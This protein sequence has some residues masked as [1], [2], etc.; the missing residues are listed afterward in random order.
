MAVLEPTLIFTPAAGRLFSLYTFPCKL[1]V[2]GEGEGI[3][4][5]ILPGSLTS[6]W[7]CIKK[8]DKKIK[9]KME[10]EFLMCGCLIYV[11][12]ANEKGRGKSFSPQKSL[13]R[14]PELPPE[15]H[16]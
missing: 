11:R 5:S 4:C 13:L 7:H 14:F 1:T 10:R 2:M 16:L 12:P 9:V 6:F 15:D 8:I 3:P